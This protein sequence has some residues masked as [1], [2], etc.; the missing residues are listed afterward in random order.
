MRTAALLV[1]LRPAIWSANGW[2]GPIGGDSRCR[3]S[4][5]AS[6]LQTEGVAHININADG[7]AIEADDRATRAKYLERICIPSDDAGL[8]IAKAGSGQRALD[9]EGLADLQLLLTAHLFACPFE[10]LDQHSH[11]A[12]D[13]VPHIP[14]K[15]A[16]ELTSLDVGQSLQKILS[17]RGGF[18]YELNLSFAWLLR[19]L[20]FRAR[21]AVADV[22]CLQEIPAHVVILIDDLPSDDASVSVLVD[23][24]FGT[25]GVCNVILPIR[26]D[27][28]TL[29]THGDSFRF[30]SSEGD[31]FD[32]TLYRK[33]I[34]TGD[35]EEESM[36][37]FHAK[38]DLPHD[39]EE[40]ALGLDRVLNRSPTFCG[41]RLC[42]ISTE[43]GHCTL[44]EGYVKWMERG[45]AVRKI[46]FDS[47]ADWR[48][49]LAEHFGVTL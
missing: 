42:V 47:E 9:D 20:G 48:E 49:A 38:D 36:Y 37:C 8:L 35:N 16:E 17:G 3:S 6:A 13:A 18:C 45:K 39:A 43:G 40:F 32:T 23:V 2:V 33:R 34:V 19:S 41:K 14:R 24:G 5:D 26:H 28:P 30:A 22:G 15:P 1:C 25:P 31:R 44:G 10:N 21:L 11:P 12:D 27:D 29:D 7:F 4:I 46:Q